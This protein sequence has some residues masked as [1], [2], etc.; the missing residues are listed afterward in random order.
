MKRLKT[1]GEP[2]EE[3]DEEAA[4]L[5]S[6]KLGKRSRLEELGKR[7]R[8]EKLGKR[9]RPEE[10]DAGMRALLDKVDSPAPSTPLPPPRDDTL[11]RL[12]KL[13]LLEEPKYGRE[14]VE[15]PKVGLPL[16]LSPCAP[17]PAPP[18]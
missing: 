1:S 6:V 5:E 4:A 7:S 17:V 9:S 8:L 10:V 14:L 13:L 2:G 18:P 3:E 11:G 16:V 12:P 15:L